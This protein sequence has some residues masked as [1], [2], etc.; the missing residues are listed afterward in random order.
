MFIGSD[1]S[2]GF[3]NGREYSLFLSSNQHGQVKIEYNGNPVLYDSI[4]PFLNNWRN[5]I[6]I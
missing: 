4:I 3:Q 6:K 5:V 1:G 2:M